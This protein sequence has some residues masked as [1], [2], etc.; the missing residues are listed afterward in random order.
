MFVVNSLPVNIINVNECLL[1]NLKFNVSSSYIFGFLN[2]YIVSF[3]LMS[4]VFK[5]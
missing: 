4:Q 1:L 3:F 5:V 2:L